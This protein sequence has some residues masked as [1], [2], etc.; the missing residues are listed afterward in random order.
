MRYSYLADLLMTLT[1]LFHCCS[2]PLYPCP[3]TNTTD[4]KLPPVGSPVAGVG[5]IEDQQEEEARTEEALQPIQQERPPTQIKPARKMKKS[6]HAPK[7]FKSSYI[8]FSTEKHKEIRQRLDGL[9]IQE[10]VR[11]A[12]AFPK[13]TIIL[14]GDIFEHQG[15]SSLPRSSEIALALTTS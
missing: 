9:G 12:N 14:V 13:N 4:S 3:P 5:A 11:A 2:C 8:F 7:R 10:K 6:P 1:V 15:P